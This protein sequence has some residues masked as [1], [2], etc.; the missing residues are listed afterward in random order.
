MSLNVSVETKTK[1]NVFVNLVVEVQYRVLANKVY[2]ECYILQDPEQKIKAFV[3][4][5]VRIQ[6]PLLDLDDVFSKKDDIAIAI[7]NELDE[8]MP[9]FG[10][11]II[12]AQ[13]TDVN[14]DANVK[15]VM[16]EINTAQPLRITATEKDKAIKAMKAKL[17][18]DAVDEDILEVIAKLRQPI[19]R[20]FSYTVISNY[21]PKGNLCTMIKG[22]IRRK[23][24]SLALTNFRHYKEFNKYN[25]WNRL[26]NRHE[27]EFLNVIRNYNKEKSN[28]DKFIFVTER[29]NSKFNIDVTD[30]PVENYKK[31]KQY[32]ED[33]KLIYKKVS[34]KRQV[35]DP[36]GGK[37]WKKEHPL[38]AFIVD[39]I[40]SS[41]NEY[42]YSNTNIH[43]KSMEDLNDIPYDLFSKPS[44]HVGYGN[45]INHIYERYIANSNNQASDLEKKK[46][47]ECLLRA[48]K[49][50]NKFDYTTKPFSLTKLLLQNSSYGKCELIEI[51]RNEEDKLDKISEF[52][53]NNAVSKTEKSKKQI[54]KIDLAMRKLGY[55]YMRAPG[56]DYI[57]SNNRNNNGEN[58]EGNNGENN[59]GNNGE[60]NE[61]NN[62]GNNDGN[63][64]GNNDRNNDGND[65]E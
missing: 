11:E 30:D 41:E 48:V 4:D 62:S 64:G 65:R 57:F 39:L 12:K 61:G 29:G 9:E 36:D 45:F 43:E 25:K 20:L 55:D 5:L 22:S 16:N 15:A 17:I 13:V 40:I 38:D 50:I 8:K 27:L 49:N 46:A 44:I 42:C 52:I 35:D 3:F 21:C 10:Y 54:K 26:N 47:A 63:N 14:P 37:K 19:I 31:K 34:V 56:F 32:I 58:N 24:F 23:H 18:E 60:N 33:L 2:E 51:L 7:K 28:E 6:V 1:D 59:E 53:K